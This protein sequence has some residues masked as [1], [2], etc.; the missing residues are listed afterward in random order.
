MPLTEESEEG[1][2]I[3]QTKAQQNFR[4]MMEGYIFILSPGFQV[5][6]IYVY[7]I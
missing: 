3:Q 1:W 7:P 6:D 4:T 2:L 5:Q